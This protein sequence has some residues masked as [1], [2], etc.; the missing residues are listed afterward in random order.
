MTEDIVLFAAGASR[1]SQA[2]KK[3]YR[4]A[5]CHY[6]GDSISVGQEP[7]NQT[8]HKK[9]HHIFDSNTSPFNRF[10]GRSYRDIRT[11]WWLIAASLSPK[12]P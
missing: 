5:D 4:R 2:A 11:L 7:M 6:N 10:P 12:K 1:A 3:K 8:V 9:G